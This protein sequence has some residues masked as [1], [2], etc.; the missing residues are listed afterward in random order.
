[1]QTNKKADKTNEVCWNLTKQTN[2]TPMYNILN[3]SQS[4]KT[5]EF[6]IKHMIQKEYALK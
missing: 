6:H 3:V 2:T 1:M 4:R 5:K